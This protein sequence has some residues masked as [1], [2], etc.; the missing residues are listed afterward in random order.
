MVDQ[1][2]GVA[3]DVDGLRSLYGKGKGNGVRK[4][5]GVVFREVDVEGGCEGGR[6]GGI[7]EVA[8]L[9]KG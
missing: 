9:M 6:G 7:V 3:G 2:T 4:N 8:D 1:V 5:F